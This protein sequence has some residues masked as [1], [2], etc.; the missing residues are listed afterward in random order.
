M[1]IIVFTLSYCA[2]ACD[3]SKSNIWGACSKMFI[4]FQH[5]HN[6]DIKTCSQYDSISVFGY[7]SLYCILLLFISVQC[8][9]LRTGEETE[10]EHRGQEKHL[11]CDNDQRRLHGCIR[12]TAQVC[13][14]LPLP[15]FSMLRLPRDRK[16]E[17]CLF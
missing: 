13:N 6:V 7:F 4:Y 10:D 8:Q 15:R 14:H 12:E 2:L 3:I 17:K 16:N 9:R 5:C 11:L 1:Y